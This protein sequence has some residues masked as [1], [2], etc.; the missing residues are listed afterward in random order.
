MIK[1]ISGIIFMTLLLGSSATWA[2]KENTQSTLKKINSKI[3]SIKHNIN[4]DKHKLTQVQQKLKHVEI[5][6]AVVSKNLH[7]TV[8]QI[9]SAKQSLGSL[10]TKE[11]W[12]REQ[13]DA[14][15]NILGQQLSRNYELWREPYFKLVLNP[16]V[17][18]VDRMLVYYRYLNQARGDTISNVKNLLGE[19]HMNVEA[20][21]HQ[22]QHLVSLEE[23]QQE[24]QKTLIT[25][26]KHRQAIVS[27]INDSI[28]DKNE[29][30]R[31]LIRNK[32]RL[33]AM[34]NALQRESTQVS[35]GFSKKRGDLHLPTNGTII[36]HYGT[37]IEQSE[38]R[39]T[40]I[41][42]KAKENSPV[43]A[44]AS[45]KV[46]FAKWMEGYGLLMIIDH[47][48]GY[49]S[50]YGR[51]HF[52]YKETGDSVHAGEVIAAVGNSGGFEEPALYFGLRH[53]GQPVNPLSWCVAHK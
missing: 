50:L 43:T 39:W 13:L 14:E 26:G 21:Q 16:D 5:A 27:K 28:N 41:L 11:T 37:Q 49:M 2:S 3:E 17:E 18:K 19:I 34:I 4:N 12:T 31:E 1:K 45:G 44:I 33:E 9:G 32:Q 46:V 42:I 52:L 25:V 6:S 29:K 51:N 15:L 10:K 36:A 23:K 38:L 47:G 30:L 35:A 40:G 22:Y 53:N 24:Q 48:G 7:A 8:H 20:Q